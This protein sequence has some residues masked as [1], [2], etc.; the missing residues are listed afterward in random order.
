MLDQ[1]MQRGIVWL[2]VKCSGSILFGWRCIEL[3]IQREQLQKLMLSC[4]IWI[5]QSLQIVRAEHMLDLQRKVS[6]TTCERVYWQMNLHKRDMFWLWNYPFKKADLN[7]SDM[8]DMD[9]CGLKIETSNLSSGKCVS[10]ECCH[11]EGAYNQERKLNLMMAISANPNYDMDWRELWPQEEGEQ[12]YLGCLRLLRVPLISLQLIG[13]A[14][15][16]ALQ[17]LI[18]PSITILFFCI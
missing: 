14:A 15:H 18:S 13:R 12:I 10:W 6:S 16:S 3:C 8:I 2:S 7:M 17:W 9:K 11:F 4:R 1:N 5:R